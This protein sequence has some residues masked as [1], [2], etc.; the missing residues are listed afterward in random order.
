[1]ENLIP[2]AAVV[3]TG[4]GGLVHL[5]I[6]IV[7]L[8]LILGLL[9]WL[10]TLLPLPDPFKKIALT[11]IIILFVICIIVALLQ[12]VG[13]VDVSGHGGSINAY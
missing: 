9:Y 6:G 4:G 1:M 3:V 13:W 11:A 7:V 2:I 8:A 5:V 12:A 10:L